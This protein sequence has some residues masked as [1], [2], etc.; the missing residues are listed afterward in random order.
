MRV[1]SR[2][3][4]SAWGAVVSVSHRHHPSA[5]TD[6]QDSAAAASTALVPKHL[7]EISFTTVLG[8]CS[9]YAAKKLAKG[10]GVAVGVTFIAFQSLVQLDL[11]QV[12]WPRIES[13]FVRA[14]DQDGDGKLTQHDLEVAGNRLTQTLSKDL[15]K[16]VGFIAAFWLG[17]RYG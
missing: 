12:N 17:F 6:K 3:I 16:G 5:M 4:Y 15:P 1:V 8:G 14:V 11:I 7:S 13:M 9:G 10:A 2:C